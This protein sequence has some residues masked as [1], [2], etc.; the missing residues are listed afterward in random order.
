MQATFRLGATSLAVLAA[1]GLTACGGGSDGSIFNGVGNHTSVIDAM[2]GNS[3]SNTNTGSGTDTGNNTGTD[4]STGGDTGTDTGTDDD[5]DTGTDTG[6]DDAN[7]GDANQFT[8]FAP[9][10]ADRTDPYYSLAGDSNYLA[11]S[12]ITNSVRGNL[13]DELEKAY[14]QRFDTTFIYNTTI[15]DGN[16]PITGKTHLVAQSLNYSQLG[17]GY[18]SY[19]MDERVQTEIDGTRYTGQRTSNLKLYQQNNSIVLGK[20]TL[21]GE[22]SDGSNPVRIEKADL[23]ID[24]IK[25]DSYDPPTAE[26]LKALQD[27]RD[28]AEKTWEDAKQAVADAEQAVIVAEQAV[29]VAKQAVIEA[30]KLADAEKLL[31]AQK[32]LSEAI[33]TERQAITA[34]SEAIIAEQEAQIAFDIAENILT[35]GKTAFNIWAR[36]PD[37][38]LARSL[39]VRGE[40]IDDTKNNKIFTYTGQAFNETSDGKLNYEIN[41][42]TR[43]GQGAITELDTGRINLNNASIGTVT[44]TNPDATSLSMLGIQGVAKFD[45]GRADGSYT[46][47]I[48]GNK[49]TEIAGVVTENNVNTVGFGG[50]KTDERESVITP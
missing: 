20:Q 14:G 8:T 18:Q 38:I 11:K 21:S 15:T 17:N 42:N 36:D 46:L 45:D 27:T 2:A 24:T 49:A 10:E 40:Y 28:S 33:L 30:E 6:G 47:G 43:T 44:H 34:R 35:D 39:G 7:T 9:N 48:F 25:G 4:T 22:L 19:T 41:F 23:R 13:H 29:I 26:E 32:Q 12:E 5:G 37:N 1:F 16:S 3:S 31:E 50:I